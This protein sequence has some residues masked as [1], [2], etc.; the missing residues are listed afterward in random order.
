MNIEKRC[1]V[2]GKKTKKD[3][4]EYKFGGNSVWLHLECAAGSQIDASANK[5]VIYYT[6]TNK[7]NKKP[8]FQ[9]SYQGD[10]GLDLYVSQDTVVL[11]KSYTDVP[12]EVAIQMPNDYFAQILPRSSTS[13]KGI[14]VFPAT[15]DPGFRGP[16]YACCWNLSSEPIM[17]KKG[18]RLAQIIFHRRTY[19]YVVEVDE[20][21]GSNRG[22]NGFGSSDGVS[23]TP[24]SEV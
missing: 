3:L 5:I 4:R 1:P 2:C 9:M 13:K 8:V 14:V 11:P 12:S 21:E 19:P 10:A 22:E 15:I 7:K 16:L 6:K 20:L 18:D 23:H 17:I 24:T